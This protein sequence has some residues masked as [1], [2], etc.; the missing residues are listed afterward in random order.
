MEIDDWFYFS[1]TL[2]RIWDDPFWIYEIQRMALVYFHFRFPSNFRF[3][4]T[5]AYIDY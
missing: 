5:Q 1:I 4:I 3:F 2:N